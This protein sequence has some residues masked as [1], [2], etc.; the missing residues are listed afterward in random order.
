MKIQIEDIQKIPFGAVLHDNELEMNLV[1][2]GR[3][4]SGDYYEL[5]SYDA[6][7]DGSNFVRHHFYTAFDILESCVIKK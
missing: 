7:M 2:V 1:F 5:K 6:S 3:T 4:P